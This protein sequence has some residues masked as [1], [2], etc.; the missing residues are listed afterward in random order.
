MDGNAAPR[1]ARNGVRGRTHGSAPRRGERARTVR[2][3]TTDDRRAPGGVGADGPG[4][5]PG[6]A[7]SRA[8]T[9]AAAASKRARLR[10]A[11]GDTPWWRRN[12][13]ANCAGW[14]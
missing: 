5:R 9:A 7:A 12:A 8:V 11:D 10:Y 1:G 3:P 4:D 13:L 2:G 14:R 6:Q